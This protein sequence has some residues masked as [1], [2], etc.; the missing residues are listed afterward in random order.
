[1]INEGGGR[2]N[3]ARVSLLAASSCRKSQVT[4]TTDES[5]ATFEAAHRSALTQLFIGAHWLW[6]IVSYEHLPTTQF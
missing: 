4:L 5:S 6:Q 1:M 2:A 3:Y